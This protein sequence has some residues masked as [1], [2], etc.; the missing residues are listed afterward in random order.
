M[1]GDDVTSASLATSSFPYEVGPSH[2][3]VRDAT[4]PSAHLLALC[5]K[6]LAT[7]TVNAKASVRLTVALAAPTILLFTVSS[8][9]R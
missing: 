7:V 6:A 1:I 8:R 4:R 2:P 5:E 9:V 3:S